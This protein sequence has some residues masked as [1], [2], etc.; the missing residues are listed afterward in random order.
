VL[1]LQSSLD[2]FL[3]AS[4]S[5]ELLGAL[6]IG[7]DDEA[8]QLCINSLV[9]HPNAQ[10]Q[11]TGRALL[12]ETLRRSAGM[13]VA[14]STGELNAPA[15]AL[16]REFGFVPYRRGEIGPEKL[17]LVKLRRAIPPP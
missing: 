7:P 11:G 1:D 13:V 6:G 15:L 8:D 5:G 12:T 4:R 9:V 10:R 16:Y 17:G 14:V 3:G 2:F